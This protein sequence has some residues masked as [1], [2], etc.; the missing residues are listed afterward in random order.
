MGAKSNIDGNVLIH[1]SS[2][3]GMVCNNQVGSLTSVFA[4]LHTG[5]VETQRCRV[6]VVVNN[7]EN[8]EH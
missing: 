7:F 6:S 2:R 1:L 4:C 3:C 5:R 8:V